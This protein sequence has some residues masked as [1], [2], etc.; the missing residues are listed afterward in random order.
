MAV[1]PPKLLPRIG[2]LGAGSIGVFLAAHL[3][4]AGHRVVL[5][6][7]PS[8]AEEIASCGVVISTWRG[9]SFV[10]GP[11]EITVTAEINALDRCDAV[12]VTVKSGATW[13]AAGTIKAALQRSER[14]PMCPIVSFQNG[15]RN[16]EILGSALGGYPVLAGMVPFN[17]VRLG[18]GRF[19]A[20][21]SGR[22]V[23]APFHE[24]A[25]QGGGPVAADMCRILT[26]AGL[27]ARPDRDARAVLWGKLLLNL[28]NPVNALSGLPLREELS[29]RGYRNV[30][31]LLVDEALG[32][33][34]AANLSVKVPGVP[35]PG[36]VPWILRLPDALF[37][38]VAA[39]M[40]RMDPLARSSMW[41]DLQRGRTTEIDDINGAVVTLAAAVGQ[42][43]PLNERIVE[44]IKRREAQKDQAESGGMSAA[45]LRRAI[46]GG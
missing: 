3:I 26:A 42:G 6:G 7:R 40:V 28:N 37:L 2:V 44:V 20:G 8:M 13:S 29:D 31:A 10:L 32:V 23:L 39:T 1:D 41:D 45:A 5:V 43:A 17:V 18:R 4:R 15:V 24:G 46:L 34:R 14:S 12:F 25:C 9:Q 36:I 38:R 33:L 35:T 22:I 19:H 27:P 30:L 21:T 11:Q 16:P